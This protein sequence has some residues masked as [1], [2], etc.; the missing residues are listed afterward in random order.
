M[1]T[2]CMLAF[3]AASNICAIDACMVTRVNTALG[4]SVVLHLSL[5]SL[6]SHVL[7]LFVLLLVCGT[8]VLTLLRTVCVS[9]VLPCC[10]IH[11]YIRPTSGLCDGAHVALVLDQR[12]WWCV[13]FHSFTAHYQHCFFAYCKGGVYVVQCKHFQPYIASHVLGWGA[14]HPPASSTIVD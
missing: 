8:F 6:C 11:V 10:C 13:G 14:T 7:S 5:P 2:Q 4:V 1:I 3:S 9:G 12:L